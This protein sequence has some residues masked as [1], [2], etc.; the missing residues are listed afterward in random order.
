[1]IIMGIDPGTCYTGVGIINYT[2]SPYKV[3]YLFSGRIKSETKATLAQKLVT[4]HRH[5]DEL[6]HRFTPDHCVIE[7]IFMA[8][9]AQSAL[10]LGHA[11][12]VALLALGQHCDSIIELSPRTI[13]KTITGSGAANKQQIQYMIQNQLKLPAPPSEDAADALA[14]ALCYTLYQPEKEPIP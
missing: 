7:K 13:K 9:N 11:R 8:K 12:G 6:L 5:L 1:M 2:R 14:M 3:G 4:I 10:K